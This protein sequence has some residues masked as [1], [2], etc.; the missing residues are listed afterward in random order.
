ME[1]SYHFAHL[2]FPWFT[3]HGSSME[4]HG[5]PTM[6]LPWNYH[7]Y[8]SRCSM[9]YPWCANHGN[10]RWAKWYENTMGIPWN[11]H[12]RN[13]W[14]SMEFSYNFAHMKFPWS[15]HHGFVSQFSMEYPWCTNHGIF[16]WAKWY[17]NSME[18]HMSWA[19]SQPMGFHG[20]AMEFSYNFAHM[21][22][23]WFAH[24]GFVSQF[25]MQYPWCTNHGNFTWAKW[26]ENSMETHMSWA[27]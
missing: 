16:T 7:G 25:S 6:V 4:I 13:P 19:W 17:E 20:I 26:Y 3:H 11:Y 8:D 14:V 24:H 9:E 12:G 1:F 2:K 5:V 15:A 27:W 21:K 23:P 18:T 22:F 10:F